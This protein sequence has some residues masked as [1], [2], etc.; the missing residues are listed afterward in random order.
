MINMFNEKIFLFLWWWYLL[1]GFLSVGSLLYWAI[2][3]LIPNWGQKFVRNYLARIDKQAARSDRRRQL[4]RDFMM[5]TLKPD[6][7]FLL[8]LVAA[9]AGD[10][11]CS[12]LLETLWNSYK[13]K[14]AIPPTPD[15]EAGNRLLPTAP[16]VRLAGKPEYPT[17]PIGSGYQP[18]PPKYEDVGDDLRQR[19]P[20][21]VRESDL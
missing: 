4:V 10:L 14:N 3:S 11:V 8:R 12:E 13:R 9:N 6:G 16:P 5:D 17:L 21:N 19:K 20:P 15:G 1:V 7:I 2:S 18:F